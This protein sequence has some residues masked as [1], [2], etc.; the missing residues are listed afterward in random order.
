MAPGLEITAGVPVHGMTSHEGG[1]DVGGV[2]CNRS[3]KIHGGSLTRFVRNL[4]HKRAT[5]ALGEV[6]SL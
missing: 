2:C 4:M 3:D 6:C 5:P 1:E